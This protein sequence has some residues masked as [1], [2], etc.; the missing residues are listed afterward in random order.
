MAVPPNENGLTEPE[1]VTVAE[2]RLVAA[3]S[4]DVWVCPM[5]A[6]A[7]ASSTGSAKAVAITDR[8]PLLVRLAEP[9]PVAVGLTCCRM[10][11]PKA[12]VAWALVAPWAAAEDRTASVPELVRATVV[13]SPL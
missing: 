5:R 7:T 3:L 8:L 9:A 1:L 10:P 2:H 12:P 6:R 13:V 4:Q 11:Q